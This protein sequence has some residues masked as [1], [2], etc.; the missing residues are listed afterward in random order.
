MFVDS[1]ISFDCR[2]HDV[3]QIDS[4][5]KRRSLGLSTRIYL[6]AHYSSLLWAHQRIILIATLRCIM[7]VQLRRSLGIGNLGLST[8]LLVFYTPDKKLQMRKSKY[9]DAQCQAFPLRY[10][11]EFFGKVHNIILKAS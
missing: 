7:A 11:T 3:V 9:V 5:V 2:L 6:T 1:I 10:C 4:P 8:Y